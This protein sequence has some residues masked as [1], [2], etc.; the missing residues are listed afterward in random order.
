MNKNN[1]IY[2]IWLSL[3]G[4]KIGSHKCSELISYYGNPQNIWETSKSDYSKLPFTSP[5]L[6]KQLSDERNRKDAGIYLKKTTDMGIDVITIEDEEYP[7]SLKNIYDPPV[8]LYVFGKLKKDERAIAVVGARNAT[9]YGLKM[10]EK[11]SYE[12]SARGITV[13][14][15][16]ARGVDSYAH[17]G[18]LA[19]GGRTIAVLGCGLDIVYPSENEKLM[20]DIKVSGAVVSE[21]LPGVLPMRYNFPARNRIISGISMGTVII[22]AGDKSGSLITADF[23]LEQGREVFAVPGNANSYYSRGTNKLIKEGAKI[24]V[25]VDDI[26]EEFGINTGFQCDANVKT[27]KENIACCDFT[28][29][30]LKVLKCIEFEPAHIDLIAQKSG[31]SLQDVNFALT[32]LELKGAVLQAPGRIFS[33]KN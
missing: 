20:N 22:E 11:L 14:S 7:E 33:I 16:M 6:V 2:W 29:N 12:L 15:G 19:A 23:A 8:A 17:R 4:S 1:L 28:D 31:L 10:A 3:L 26:I 32:I 25:S 21:Y 9:T 30:E 24:V 18:A 27:E 5:A 13:A